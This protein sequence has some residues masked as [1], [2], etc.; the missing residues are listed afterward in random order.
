MPV[1]QRPC[2][3]PLTPRSFFLVPPAMAFRSYDPV[4]NP[5]A[6]AST[7]DF[8]FELHSPRMG[9]FMGPALNDEASFSDTRPPSVNTGDGSSSVRALNR[10]SQADPS[11][12]GLQY[13]DDPS[14]VQPKE[15]ATPTSPTAPYAN[16]NEKRRD[17]SSQYASPR[18]RSR[19]RLMLIIGGVALIIIIVVVVVAVT[20][21]TRKHSSSSS[22]DIASGS[23]GSSSQGGG[24]SS[25]GS[26]SGGGKT[27][28]AITGGD[29]STVTLAD[30]STFTYAN[31][32]GGYWYY[33]PE[34][35]LTNYARAQSWTPAM[36][37]T[38]EYGTDNIRGCVPGAVSHR[39]VER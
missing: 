31:K 20:L 6:A 23:S 26:T 30:G 29:G 22:S 32:F 21:S 7:P 5:A 15:F 37:E 34:N 27:T 25:S 17:P 24:K 10:Q 3:L 39:F 19:R 1:T 4:P 11:V 16:L 9:T 18:Q 38:F 28:A 14:E 8:D 33:D 12:Y 35:P 13:R 2:T 36:N